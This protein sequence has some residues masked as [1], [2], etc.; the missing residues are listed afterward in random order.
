M[1]KHKQMLI[2][3]ISL[4]LT[5]SYGI[6]VASCASASSSPDDWSM[7]R[8]D[9]NHSGYTTSSGQANSFKLLWNY[10]AGAAVW[11]SPSVVNGRVFV[12]CRDGN[13]FCLNST[14]GTSLWGYQTR[15]VVQ[16]SSPAI[17]NGCIYIGSDDGCINCLD[18]NTG[19]PFWNS[20]VGFM[21]KSSPAVVE[22]RVYVGSS[23]HNVYCLNASDGT[24]IW[25]YPTLDL[26]DSSPAVSNGVVYVGS[27]D[28]C[29]YALN[30]LTG[31]EIWQHPTGSSITSSPS[32][33]NG[34]V[35]I[36]S[37]DGCVYAFNATTGEQIWE[38]QTADSVVS[39]PAI[40]YGC[41]F[42]G[43]NDNNVYCLNA[44]TG[45]KIWQSP[46]GYWVWSSPAVADGNV[47]VGSEDW[48]IYCLNASTGEKKWRYETGNSV[49]SSPAIANGVLYFGSCDF[50]I[51][52]LALYDSTVEPLPLP[53]TNP[54]AWTIV[55]FDV[56]AFAI[57]SVIILAIGVSVY[58][59]VRPK[60]N[61]EAKKVISQKLPWLSAHADGLCVVAILAAFSII[62]FFNL[63]SG[64]LWGA[65]EQTYS[66][67]AFHMVKT[68]DYLTPWAFGGLAIWMGKPPLIIWLMSL[69]Y[70]VFGVNN[71][72]TRFWSPI[73][74]VLSCVVVFYLGKI[75]YN[76]R[77][78]LLSAIVLG[79]FTTFYSF[80]RHAMTEMPLVFFTVASIYFMV[81]SQKT[82]SP[83]R[84]A[85]LSGLFFGLAFMT[86]QVQAL[87]IPLIIFAFLA[88]T[89]RSLRFL[90]TKWFTLFWGVSLLVFAPWLIYMNAHF[91]SE[92]WKWFFMYNVVMRTVEPLEGHVG[93]YLFYFNYLVTRENWLWVIMLPFA[94]G[95]CVYNA[96]V[97][98]LK[99]DTFILLW[100]TIVL[101]VFTFAQTKLYWYILPALPAFALVIS[102]FLYQLYKKT[103]P[104]RGK[105][106]QTPNEG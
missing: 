73:F 94:T 24:E 52:A 51:Y 18:I 20:H 28:N 97:K 104:L 71:F 3:L 90:F 33:H 85:T 89:Q 35:Y 87:L 76:R 14:D 66:Q 53:S 101:G 19:I 69:S 63:E 70:Q 47:Y 105:L 41:V 74:G 42:V 88:T 4:I 26:V 27:A 37:N 57:G 32:V 62:F 96:V 1:R 58:S 15:S 64:P 16:Y 12:G 95:L 40:A 91:G 61:A 46:T 34:Y 92:F 56:I 102:S 44:S 81:L 83:N 10:T 39:S 86:K 22:G 23:D 78:G 17:V 93:S 67:W 82:K 8:R 68:G 98:R 45:K 72:A 80:A 2:I 65:D 13:V 9:P 60:Q 48:N 29:I 55:A 75:L 7:F 49:D 84:Y 99:Q 6:S 77:I 103:H 30:A 79:T 5:L 100:I 38:Y 54:S 11:S 36:G 25:S 50:R 106:V 43:S 59:T 21:V 31:T